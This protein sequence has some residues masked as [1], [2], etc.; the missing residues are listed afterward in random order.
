[1]DPY[2]QGAQPS[3]IAELVAYIVK[4]EAYFMSGKHPIA[5]ICERRCMLMFYFQDKL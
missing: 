5:F 4:P 2:Y 1:M 3:V